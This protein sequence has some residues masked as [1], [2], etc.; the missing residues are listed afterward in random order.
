MYIF[1]APMVRKC[2]IFV[3]AL[4]FARTLTAQEVVIA[5]R[6]PKI[7]LEQCQIADGEFLY[8]G[9]IHSVSASCIGTTMK[10]LDMF[11]YMSKVKVVLFTKERLVNADEW[12]QHI[13]MQSDNVV[14]EAFDVFN[15]YNIEY[16]PFGVLL[17][18]DRK[19]VWFGNPQRVDKHT[20]ENTISKWSSQK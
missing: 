12:L 5:E 2:I 9:F 20:I 13:A 18:S 10:I 3:S 1:V 11:K 19:A 15:L 4:L 14:F 16:A 8:M 7:K 17:N 6:A